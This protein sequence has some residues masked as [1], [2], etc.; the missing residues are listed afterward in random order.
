MFD[1]DRSS[2]K[3]WFFVYGDSFGEKR[4]IWRFDTAGCHVRTLEITPSPH[5]H[6]ELVAAGDR[7]VRFSSSFRSQKNP[8]RGGVFRLETFDPDGIRDVRV[9]EPAEPS[10]RA[11]FLGITSDGLLL[12]LRRNAVEGYG[13]PH[14]H[15]ALLFELPEEV[16][17]GRQRPNRLNR[18]ML[19]SKG[20]GDPVIAMVLGDFWTGAMNN[21][22]DKQEVKLLFY[23]M[24]DGRP[25]WSLKRRLTYFKIKKNRPW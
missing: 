18:T 8:I 10:L 24:R 7:L 5:Q 13:P 4:V 12:I 2:A 6:T 23:N 11:N 9:E 19:V 15:R 16:L 17:G 21:N 3:D 22:R 1:E 25:V 14:F 20:R